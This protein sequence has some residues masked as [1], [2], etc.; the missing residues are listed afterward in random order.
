MSAA[1]AS[2]VVMLVWAG[3]RLSP[4]TIPLRPATVLPVLLPESGHAAVGFP[5]RVVLATVANYDDEV[6]AY[7]MTGYL[8]GTA[9]FRDS[10]VLLTYAIVDHRLTYSIRIHPRNLDVVSGLFLLYSAAARGLIAE[11]DWRLLDSRTMAGF[12][13]QNELFDTSYNLPVR[14]PLSRLSR[15]EIIAYASRFVRFKSASD[16]RTW[17]RN[18]ASLAPLGSAQATQFATDVVTIAEFYKLPVEFFFGIGAMENNYMNAEGDADHAI[19]KRRAHP[20]DIVLKRARG[21]V[22]VRDSSQGVWQITRETLRRTH[23]L[24]LADRRDYSTLPPGLRPPKQLDLDNVSSRVLTTYAGL[25]FRQ[26]LDRCGGDVEMA[27]GAYNGG[28]GN[29]NLLYAE[30][31]RAAATHAR[32]VI[33]HA[34]L[35]SGPVAGRNFVIGAPAAV[36]P[37]SNPPLSP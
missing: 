34:A 5:G 19:W 37:R 3:L 2:A 32:A 33:E 9:T 35:L 17:R 12:R 36:P 20:G 16:P 24:Y 30:G 11:P 21:R 14:R 4:H 28:L 18:A 27:L 29:P 26:L 6:F 25:L 10:E 15:S 31:V 7:L 1:V 8:R 23:A 22:L 13:R